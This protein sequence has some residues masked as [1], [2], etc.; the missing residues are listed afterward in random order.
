MAVFGG[1]F[2]LQMCPHDEDSFHNAKLFLLKP[3]LK[4]VSMH[5][6]H[7]FAFDLSA[8]LGLKAWG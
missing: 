3:C 1:F 6:L 8:R 2:A 4:R 7:S 5:Q